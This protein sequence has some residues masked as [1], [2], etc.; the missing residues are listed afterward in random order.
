M[1]FGLVSEKILAI[2]MAQWVRA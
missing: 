2:I 1:D